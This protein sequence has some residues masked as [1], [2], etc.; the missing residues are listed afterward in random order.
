MASFLVLLVHF[1]LLYPIVATT[2]DHEM[3]FKLVGELELNIGLIRKMAKTPE[4]VG[5]YEDLIGLQTS[6]LQFSEAFY[7]PNILRLFCRNYKGRDKKTENMINKFQYDTTNPFAERVKPQFLIDANMD[8]FDKK[9]F[10]FNEND[11]KDESRKFFHDPRPFGVNFPKERYK[12]IEKIMTRRIE[13]IMLA[14]GIISNES[15]N[16]YHSIITA[17][18]QMK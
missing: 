4:Y 17:Y 1:F 8:I 9:N 3:L 5:F 13:E 14:R 6:L 2:F 7:Q 16:C 11:F 15:M 12:I 18:L 10:K